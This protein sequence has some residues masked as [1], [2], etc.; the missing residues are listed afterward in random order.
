MVDRKIHLFFS[1]GMLIT[2][3]MGLSFMS[4]IN[5]GDQV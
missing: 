1:S 4:L 2:H 3:K 5:A